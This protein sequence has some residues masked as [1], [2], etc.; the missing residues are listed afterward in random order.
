MKK[1]IL[2][3]I[4]TYIGLMSI[5][6]STEISSRNWNNILKEWKNLFQFK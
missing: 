1:M 2:L 4:H 5:K 3:H 6:I